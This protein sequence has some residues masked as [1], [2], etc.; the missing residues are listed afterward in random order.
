MFEQ[1]SSE[2]EHHL[3]N[4]TALWRTTGL[5]PD[6]IVDGIAQRLAQPQDVLTLIKLFKHLEYD[7]WT[8]IAVR[9]LGQAGT[10][11]VIA[12]LIPLLASSDPVQASCAAAALGY[13][14]TNQAV[15][16]LITALQYSAPVPVE[17]GDL[18]KPLHDVRATAAH[19][20]GDIGDQ[21]AV[22]ALIRTLDDTEVYVQMAAAHALGQLAHERA[23]EPLITKLH[24]IQQPYESDGHEFLAD[25][26]VE[27]LGKIP[28]PASLRI[29]LD[30]LSMTSPYHLQ[31]QAV[32]ALG[33]LKNRDA[34]N[35]LV[36]ALQSPNVEVK[37]AAAVALGELGD[38]RAI[39]PLIE[40]LK[41]TNA[42]TRACAAQSL[43]SLRDRRAL[44]ALKY[45]Q[46][47]PALA[48][49]RTTVGEL[50][51]EAINYI[52]QYSEAE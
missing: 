33:T 52:Q 40:A 15:D 20:L 8:D 18:G 37:V 22:A 17:Y 35:A 16:A 36:G 9:A 23:V 13:A 3:N 2:L 6:E 14:G 39:M 50:A 21:R 30:L 24:Q 11:D 4:I 42:F 47:D 51:T 38:Q 48:Y 19:A 29:L 46:N 28:T 44:S 41:D 12:A 34:L 10:P 32:H 7:P 26:I 49:G 45:I 1:Q 31:S 27:A 25:T 43:G 5:N